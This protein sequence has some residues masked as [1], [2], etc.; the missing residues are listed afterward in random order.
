MKKRIV[1]ITLSVVVVGVLLCGAALGAVVDA[2]GSGLA[3]V[4]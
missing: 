3:I 4:N 2:E 1:K